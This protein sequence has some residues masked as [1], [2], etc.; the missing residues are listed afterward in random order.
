MSKKQTQPRTQ[1]QTQPQTPQMIILVSANG[2]QVVLADAI[3]TDYHGWQVKLVP[4]E[5]DTEAEIDNSPQ[6]PPN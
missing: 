6:L 3:K 2:S 1:P 4:V 5:V